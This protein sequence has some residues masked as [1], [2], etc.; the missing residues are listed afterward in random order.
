[1]SDRHIQEA[2]SELAGTRTMDALN[3]VVAEVES[4]SREGRSCSCRTIS[5][6]SEIVFDGVQLMAAVDDGFLRIPAVGSTVIIAYSKKVQPFVVLFSELDAV[7]VVAGSS[8]VEMANDGSIVLNGG[9]LGGLVQVGKLVE[10][11]QGIEKSLQALTQMY[12]V[13][14]HA[15]AGA[16]TVSLVTPFTQNTVQEDIENKNIT[17]G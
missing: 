4:V 17:Q 11:L 3:A 10:K 12:N 8:S 5:G 14:V 7:V 6:D 16:P 1:M 15:S 9:A 2:I 13:H